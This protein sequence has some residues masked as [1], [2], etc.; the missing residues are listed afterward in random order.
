[1][2]FHLEIYGFDNC[3][4]V[5]C[6]DNRMLFVREIVVSFVMGIVENFQHVRVMRKLGSKAQVNQKN[7]RRCVRA[8]T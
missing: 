6:F 2:S 1:M 4:S 5:F 7:C 8:L 3:D